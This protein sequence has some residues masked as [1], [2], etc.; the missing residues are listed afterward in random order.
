MTNATFP[1]LTVG[2]SLAPILCWAAEPNFDRAKA[3]AEIEKSG[4]RVAVDE[5]SPGKEVIEV[6]FDIADHDPPD[7]KPND[8]TLQYLKRFKQLRVLVLSYSN[9]SDS[10]LVQLEG[11]ISSRSC[12]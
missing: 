4:C 3:I 9:I 10:G 5:K 11:L 8:T 6:V 1:L 12:S 2:L 7:P